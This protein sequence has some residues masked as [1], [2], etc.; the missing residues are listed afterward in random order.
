MVSGDSSAPDTAALA[1]KIEAAQHEAAALSA[2]MAW[3]RYVRLIM[4]VALVAFVCVIVSLFWRLGQRITSPENVD[5]I[6]ARGE[7]R[8]ADPKNE[9]MY[10]VQLLVDHSSP[11]LSQA[12]TEQARKDLPGFLRAMEKERD[13][14]AVSLQNKLEAKLD[15]RYRE[16][17]ERHQKVLTDEFPQAQNE[18]LRAKMVANINLAVERLVK[19]YY[20]KE[21]EA[22]LN[23]LYQAWDDFPA[24]ARPGP[25]DYPLEEQFISYLFELLRIKLAHPGALQR[26]AQ[27]ERI[28][29]GG[30][31]GM[32][33]L[34]RVPVRQA[35][36]SELRETKP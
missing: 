36:L 17:V 2:A 18:E 13:Q 7:E 30:R 28:E 6:V 3:A 29:Q 10:Q 27:S 8:L 34:M 31:T 35:R 1:Q 16:V 20:V 4:F 32:V 25:N 11:V 9:Y 22:Q 24:A 15:T 14:L 26:I 23:E 21:L 12:F 33:R 5:K 19:K